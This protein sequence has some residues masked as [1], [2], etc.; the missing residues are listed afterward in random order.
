MVK[1]NNNNTNNNPNQ[2]T[3]KTRQ[4][5]FFG[6]PGQN[7]ETSSKAFNMTAGIM[8]NVSKLFFGESLVNSVSSE[9]K[10]KTLR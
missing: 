10:Q 9:K 1:T 5:T 8:S 3:N 7:K 6:R 4:L 2:P